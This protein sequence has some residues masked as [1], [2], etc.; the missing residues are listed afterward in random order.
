MLGKK[1]KKE[2]L[3]LLFQVLVSTMNHSFGCFYRPINFNVKKQKKDRNFKCHYSVYKSQRRFCNKGNMKLNYF[4][5][6]Y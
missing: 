4:L 1:K 6:K 2:N 3:F 5:Q